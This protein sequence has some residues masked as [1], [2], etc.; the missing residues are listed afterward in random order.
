MTEAEKHQHKIIDRIHT[1]SD[2]VFAIVLTL[3]ILEIKLPDLSNA[4]SSAEMLNALWLVAPKFFAFLLSA[5]VVGSNWLSSMQVQPLVVRYNTH[6]LVM[7]VIYIIIIALFPFCCML[8][9]EYPNNPI[10][11]VVFGAVSSLL[12]VCGYHYIHYIR[13]KNL[14]HDK[15]DRTALERSL[16][17]I[18]MVFILIVG[19]TASAFYNTKLSFALFI[20]F[21]LTPFL[22][23]AQLKINHEE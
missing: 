4:N 6:Y 21:N 7:M 16:K 3:L 1:F 11:F 12:F 10:S 5:L 14:I 9:G 23:T 18:P 19:I 13:K 15:T 2:A 17:F 8:I 20:L 22:V